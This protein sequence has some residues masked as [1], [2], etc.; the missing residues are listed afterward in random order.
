M[1]SRYV[2]TLILILI[3]LDAATI[4]FSYAL[5]C[6]FNNSNITLPHLSLKIFGFINAAWFL[7]ASFTK[8]YSYKAVQTNGR[9][10]EKSITVY[11][12]QFLLVVLAMFTFKNLPLSNI[13]LYN[14]LVCEF[15]CLVLVRVVIYYIQKY[16]PALISYKRKIAIVGSNELS[17]RLKDYFHQNKLSFNLLRHS[18]Y[19]KG[20]SNK[21]QLN[22][23]KADIQYA[24]EH[25]L[26][27]VYTTLFPDGQEELA[28]VLKLAE[29]SFVRVRF[30]TTNSK[31]KYE[32]EDFTGV[33][34]NLNGY[35]NGLSVF[36]NRL[37][38]LQAVNNR[39]LKRAFD[40]M[41]SLCVIVFLLSWLM[42]LL[43]LLIKL[44]SRGPVIFPQLRSGKNNKP[45]WCYKFRSMRTSSNCNETQATSSDPRITKIGAFIR[46]TSID[47]LPQ[48]FNVLFGDMS[49]VGPRPHM[50]KHTDEYREIIDQ[51]MIR[52]YLKPGITGWAQVNGFRGETKDPRLMRERVEHDLWYM[53]NWSVLFDMKIVFLTVANIFKG[54]K[55]AY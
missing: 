50:L 44:E 40:I 24:V 42:P 38:P 19:T 5:I 47:E 46:K 6:Y 8:L 33:K 54:E 12:C 1:E 15:V 22:E 43:G 30:V 51:Y 18:A 35:Y 49:I 9:V 21:H 31:Y 48:F 20:M 4:N 10:W 23:L 25:Q 34:Y 32:L 7:P 3:L 36:V 2:F 27:E 52:L 11:C 26:D 14:I 28:E 45:F 29:Q 17:E 55:N 16:F 41:F 39:I 53:E 13:L 37:E